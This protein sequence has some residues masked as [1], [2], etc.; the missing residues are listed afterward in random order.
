MEK[1]YLE[2]RDTLLVPFPHESEWKPFAIEYSRLSLQKWVDSMIEPLAGVFFEYFEQMKQQLESMGELP[3]EIRNEIGI[4]AKSNQRACVDEVCKKAALFYDG[5]RVL[6]KAVV[7]LGIHPIIKPVQKQFV[8][9]FIQKLTNIL[10]GIV[11]NTKVE[12]KKWQ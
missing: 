1:H 11:Q 12:M 4:Y 8:K 9:L 3:R 2:R 10:D 7:R 5:L 6:N